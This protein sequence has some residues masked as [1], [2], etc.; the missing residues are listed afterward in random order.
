MIRLGFSPLG[1]L[2]AARILCC[3]FIFME[4]VQSMMAS[5]DPM[6]A[7]PTAF[8]PK[9]SAWYRS[10]KIATHRFWISVQLGYCSMSTKF[11]F[12]ASLMR[13]SH[14]GSIQVVTKLA[15]F[16]LGFLSSILS[17]LMSCAA[18][19]AGSPL[20]GMT[21][22]GIA[23][24]VCLEAKVYCVPTR[25]EK[26]R[27]RGGCEVSCEQRERERGGHN[28][29]ASFLPEECR[30]RRRA[31]SSSRAWP[32][33]LLLRSLLSVLLPLQPYSWIMTIMAVVI[34]DKSILM[35]GRS[36][37]RWEDGGAGH[38]DGEGGP[39]DP[40]GTRQKGER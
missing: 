27:G 35:S 21:Y 5:L 8:A 13:A 37:G 1:S 15:R 26:E 6:A 10:A 36:R 34:E 7:V 23:D 18:T 17:S 22:F 28:S 39:R 19:A 33:S 9:S 3:H 4:R 24:A 31:T 14:S 32:R 38:F 20:L 29:S 12:R 16:I 30:R 25:R 2:P 11:T 40:Q